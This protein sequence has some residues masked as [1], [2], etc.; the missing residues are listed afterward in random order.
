MAEP[1]EPAADD[2]V[3]RLN[4]EDPIAVACR[5]LQAGERVTLAQQSLTLR[6]AVPL[7]HKLAVQAIAA[8]EVVR[9]LGVPIGSATQP[10]APGEHI[11]THNLKSDYLPTFER[12]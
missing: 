1:D 3:L 2:A 5:D 12:E 7:G 11:H 10:I 6:D 9:K 8:G 4:P